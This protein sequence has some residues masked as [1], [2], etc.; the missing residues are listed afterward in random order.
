M[1]IYAHHTK[2]KAFQNIIASREMWLHAVSKQIKWGELEL[3]ANQFGLDGY[4]KNDG[5]GNRPLESLSG[6]MFSLSLTSGPPSDEM[7]GNRFGPIRM[8][9]EVCPILE[10][11]E[12][13]R[14]AYSSENL[15]TDH[16][17]TML[18]EVAQR[19]FGKSFIPKK[20]NRAGAF[21]LPHKY[22]DQNEVRLLIKRLPGSE[23]IDTRMFNCQ[24]LLPIPLY[25]E[26]ERVCIRLVDVQV[27]NS[28]LVD[29]VQ[30]A[31]RQVA[32]WAVTVSFRP[33]AEHAS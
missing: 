29:P 2:L 13:R 18:C 27:A 24:E 8:N 17:L 9:L 11:S 7:W 4:L 5:Q 21:F 22:Q 19:R 23:A 20:L 1:G 25:R 30:A 6:N 10:R 28:D 16:P 12:L 3:F 26:H 32:E 33:P 14:V 15:L 31:L